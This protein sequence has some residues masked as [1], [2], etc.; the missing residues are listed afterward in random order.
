MAEPENRCEDCSGD[1]GEDFY[2]CGDRMLCESCYSEGYGYCE[3]CSETYPSDDFV[4]VHG[5]RNHGGDQYMC[6]GCAEEHPECGKCDGRYVSELIRGEY[7]NAP[8]CESCYDSGDFASCDDC[9]DIED[10]GD[11][12]R[13]ESERDTRDLCSAC[14]PDCSERK[15]CGEVWEN[16]DACNCPDPGPETWNPPEGFAEACAVVVWPIAPGPVAGT[17][18]L[19]WPR[20]AERGRIDWPAF[21]YGPLAVHRERCEDGSAGRAWKVTHSVSGLA[22]SGSLETSEHSHALAR[23]LQCLPE[24]AEVAADAS[25]PDTVR[26]SLRVAIGAARAAVTGREW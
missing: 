11:I 2:T 26:D 19:A 6:R 18:S 3:S 8:L 20:A 22:I 21:L 5:L 9:G 23:A 7:D 17:V 24:W 15:C 10:S 25:M 1:A 12:T 16:G 13:V 4:Q 14:L